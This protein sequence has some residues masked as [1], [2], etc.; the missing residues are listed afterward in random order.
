M[1]FLFK[2]MKKRCIQF[3]S[4]IQEKAQELAEEIVETS[5]YRELKIAES[6]IQN[7]DE[8]SQLMEDFQSTQQRMQMAQ[9]NGK[10][11]TPQQQKQ[12]QSLQAQMQQNEVIKNFMEKQQQ[13]NQVM[14]TVNQVISSKLQ[15]Q[16]QDQAE[17]NE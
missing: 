6:A 12:A 7:D 8:A 10:Q 9:S 11:V 13:F 2:I 4:T 15:E 5:E 1:L 17:D 16:D 14:Q 3:M